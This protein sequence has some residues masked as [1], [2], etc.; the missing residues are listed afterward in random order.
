[1]NKKER[2]HIPNLIQSGTNDIESF[3]NKTLRPIIKMQHDLLIVS[4]QNYL[5]K[6]KIDFSNLSEDQKLQRIESI[7]LKDINYKNIS[8]GYTVGHFSIEEFEFYSMNSSEMN[9]R[10]I[11]IVQKRI[12]D[13][14]SELI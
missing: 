4:F 5:Q 12:Q 11:K 6:R 1:M 2:P 7:F 8:L 3:Q 13:S 14:L 9:K 10:I